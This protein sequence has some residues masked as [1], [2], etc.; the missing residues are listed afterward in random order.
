VIGEASADAGDDETAALWLVSFGVESTAAVEAKAQQLGGTVTA[1][2]DS[3]VALT[4]PHGCRFVA[5][6][7]PN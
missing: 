1:A 6:P 2:V 3:S 4:D 5:V 7:A